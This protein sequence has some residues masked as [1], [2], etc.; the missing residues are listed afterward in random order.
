MVTTKAR[1]TRRTITG[2]AATNLR[3]PALGAALIM[4]A[5]SHA[6]APPSTQPHRPSARTVPEIKTGVRAY[7]HRSYKIALQHF[8]RAITTDDQSIE[9][10]YDRALTYEKLHNYKGAAADLKTV[11]HARPKWA[12][13]RLHLAAAQYHARDFAGSARNFDIALR[14]NAKNWRVWLDDG[15]I[16]YALHRY[17]DAR[18]RL[19]RAL[20]LSPKSGRAHFWLGMTY[21]HLH[22]APRARGELALAAHSRDIVV[23]TAAQNALAVR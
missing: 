12:A 22:N 10:R 16:Y 7:N 2:T 11:V 5:C 4:S 8:D 18:R 19:A 20:D 1:T 23:R 21:R 6:G 15:V 13:A 3:V 9:A 17:T 14:A